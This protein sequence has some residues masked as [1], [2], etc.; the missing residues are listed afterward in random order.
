[1]RDVTQAV[2][3]GQHAQQHAVCAEHE[4]ALR[5][6]PAGSSAPLKRV[7]DHTATVTSIQRR[8]CQ[9]MSSWPFF[10]PYQDFPVLHAQGQLPT[11]C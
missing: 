6:S 1:M 2:P 3:A 10:V 9:P 4:R 5:P 8:F 7:Y 11:M